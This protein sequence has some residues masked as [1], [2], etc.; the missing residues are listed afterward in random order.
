MGS[1][2]IICTMMSILGKRFGDAGLR[3]LCI[4]AGIIA[5][6]SI[7]AV[8]D[9]H[10]YNRSIR[11]HKLVYE[12]LMRLAWKEFQSWCNEQQHQ[13]H[14]DSLMTKIATLTAD[15]CQTTFEQV[16]GS[17]SFHQ[18]ANLFSEFREHLRND[19]GPLACF[20]SSYLEM[21]EIVLNLVRASHE[22]NWQMH[23]VAIDDMIPWCFSYDR[24]KYARYLSSYYAEMTHLGEEHHNNLNFISFDVIYQTM[25]SNDVNKSSSLYFS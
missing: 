16:M 23:L 18:V 22:G 8:M 10:V 1:F 15:L 21:V 12:A 4:E 25:I 6:G 24:I 19:N 11:V 20:W 17:P 14:V 9:G 13:A 5:E 2:H 3:D 7:N